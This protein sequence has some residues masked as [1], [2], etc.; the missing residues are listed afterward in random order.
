MSRTSARS[1]AYALSDERS[2]RRA[3]LRLLAFFVSSD[4]TVAVRMLA[5]SGVNVG[6]KDVNDGFGF[7]IVSEDK[8]APDSEASEGRRGRGRSGEGRGRAP[9]PE[10]NEP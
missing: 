6:A 2:S 1:A 4:A 3:F 5:L 9:P 8:D 7:S 10:P